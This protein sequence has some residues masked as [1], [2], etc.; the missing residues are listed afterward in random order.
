MYVLWFSISFV[1]LRRV[2]LQHLRPSQRTAPVNRLESLRNLGRVFRGERLHFFV[3]AGDINNSQRIFVNLSSTRKLV[4]GQK[5]KIRLMDRVS[6]H[7]KFGARNISRRGKINLPESLLD[8]PL[9]GGILRHFRRFC[10][11]FDGRCAFSV[12]LGAVVDF[13][14]FGV[15]LFY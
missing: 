8:E 14:E 10:Q 11:Y 1:T 3:K 12:A 13:G 15:H 4:M 7:I 5:K 9:L 2:N 6:R